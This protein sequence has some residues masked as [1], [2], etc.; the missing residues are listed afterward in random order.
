MLNQRRREAYGWST[1]DGRLTVY[2]RSTAYARLTARATPAAMV[3][4]RIQPA[5]V[6][7]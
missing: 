2:A 5:A 7:R 1:A 4:A 3:V 6:R